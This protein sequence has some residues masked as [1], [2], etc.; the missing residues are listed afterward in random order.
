MAARAVSGGRIM[1]GAR[2]CLHRSAWHLAVS[3]SN[4]HTNLPKISYVIE[5]YSRTTDMDD[6]TNA[7]SFGTA[8]VC[9]C[10]QYLAAV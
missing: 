2:L 9:N 7:H 10:E 5:G 6:N 1:A 8:C 4:G 3:M